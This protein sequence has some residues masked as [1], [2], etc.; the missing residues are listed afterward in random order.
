[1]RNITKRILESKIIGK[2]PLGKPR[3]RWVN[4]IEIENRGFESDKLE[5]RLSR[6]ASLEASFEG[7]QGSSFR[8]SRHIRRCSYDV[9]LTGISG[10]EAG[11]R[12]RQRVR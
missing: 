6:Q 12:E 7:G 8:P 10:T 3:K 1:L 9:K 2:G 5:K 4:E 11:I